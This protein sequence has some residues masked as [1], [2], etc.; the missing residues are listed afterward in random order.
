M[1]ENGLSSFTT[2]SSYM[3]SNGSADAE[4]LHTLCKRLHSQV[5]AF[6]A[7]DFKEEIFRNTQRQC[8]HSL[9]IIHEALE[10]YPYVHYKLYGLSRLSPFSMSML[11]TSSQSL[12]YPTL[13]LS[14]NGGKDCLVL[15]ILYLAA[16]ASNPPS[17]SSSSS[18][19]STKTAIPTSLPS[20]Y[21]PPSNPFPAQDAFVRSSS[22][23]Y[24]LSLTQH[25]HPSMKTAFA[26]YLSSPDGRA[27]KAIF[28]G[29]RR[30][31]P[32]GSNLTAFD[33]TDRGWPSFMRVHPVLEW[34]YAEI[35][36]FLRHLE[37]G[38]CELYNQGFTSLGGREDTKPNPRLAII[39][40]VGGDGVVVGGFKP[41]YELVEDSE[42]RL[43]RE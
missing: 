7:E 5:E 16:L 25:S 22:I 4:S 10:K 14:Y 37:V 40:E 2:G 36:A 9:S 38:Y 26:A 15:L 27:I 13:S 29:T 12:R 8:R 6:L 28:V 30:T 21:I 41:A 11:L 19:S 32:H 42:E 20:I 24:H 23:H 35:W 33:M 34:R 1:T 17:S 3:Q 39:K 43:G 18:T 31:D